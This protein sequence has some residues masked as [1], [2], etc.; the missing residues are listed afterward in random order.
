MPQ[1]ADDFM[2]ILLFQLIVAYI[3]AD[4]IV[5]I[6][7]LFLIAA[8]CHRANQLFH[9]CLQRLLMLLQ[10]SLFKKIRRN[11]F[12]I[13]GIGIIAILKCPCIEQL[14]TIQTQLHENIR[15]RSVFQQR[16]RKGG[17]K[18]LQSCLHRLIAA[19]LRL[20]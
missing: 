7:Q 6:Q 20:G 14:R 1:N 12:C 9:A 17:R 18:R 13:S 8:P 10:L 5:D 19:L 11:Q 15:Q 2:G 4:K 16:Y 3:F